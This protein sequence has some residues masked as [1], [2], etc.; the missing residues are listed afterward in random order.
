MY[1]K[2][3]Y[4]LEFTSQVINIQFIIIKI[5]LPIKVY[6]EEIGLSMKKVLV[7]VL[8]TFQKYLY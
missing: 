6:C 3:S 4:L 5:L 7:F 1:I 8:N 2:M